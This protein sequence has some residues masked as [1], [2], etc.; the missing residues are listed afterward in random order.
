MGPA[1]VGAGV[2]WNQMIDTGKLR[3]FQLPL[4]VMLKNNVAISY[5]IDYM[6]AIGGG[7]QVCLS[8]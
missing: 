7:C 5:F 3:L 1:G 4:E 2:D 6:T 8:K